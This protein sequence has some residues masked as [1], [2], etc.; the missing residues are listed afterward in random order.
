M[1]EHDTTLEGGKVR[2]ITAPV[3][4]VWVVVDAIVLDDVFDRVTMFMMRD[5]VR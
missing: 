1:A 3:T 2:G 5:D 4:G